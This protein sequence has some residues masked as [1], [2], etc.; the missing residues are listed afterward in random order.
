MDHVSHYSLAEID[1][2]L[3]IT[4]RIVMLRWLKEHY[5]KAQDAMDYGFEGATIVQKGAF[6]VTA[7]E[8]SKLIDIKH[9]RVG[10]R[11]AQLLIRI[12]ESGVLPSSLVVQGRACDP[13]FYRFAFPESVPQ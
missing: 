1:Q 2:Y 7:E 4:N 11:G 9:G 3:P 13:E 5:E 12:V 6:V 8:L 10:Q